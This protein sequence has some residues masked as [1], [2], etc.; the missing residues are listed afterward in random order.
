MVE[1]LDIS[2]GIYIKSA[3]LQSLFSG[4][5]GKMGFIDHNLHGEAGSSKGF[6]KELLGVL[7]WPAPFWSVKDDNNNLG[8]LFRKA[9]NGYEMTGV[10]IIKSARGKDNLILFLLQSSP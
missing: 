8:I 7:S 1:T 10:G 2:R 9:F 4:D 5:P 6:F 3:N